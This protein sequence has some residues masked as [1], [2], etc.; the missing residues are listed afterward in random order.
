MSCHEGGEAE[1]RAVV[2]LARH[3]LSR[4][5]HACVPRP[6]TARVG[7]SMRAQLGCVGVGPHDQAQPLGVGEAR[8]P[9]VRCA[10]LESC[11]QLAL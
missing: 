7:G 6:H 1:C 10:Q 5:R 8:R 11:A 2:E 4:A 3:R 9:R